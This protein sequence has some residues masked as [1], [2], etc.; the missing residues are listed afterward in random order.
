MFR[1]CL[2]GTAVTLA[3]IAIP[4]VH[5][6]TALPAPF[7]GGY[8]A[9][10]RSS[11]SPGQALIIG[12]AMGA[13]LLVPIGGILGLTAL[14]FHFSAQLMLALTMAYA[15]YVAALGTLGA[16]VGGSSVR[17]QTAA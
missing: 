16:A 4:V 7:I 5:W 15:L 13:I 14:F 17:R 12:P 1:A 6:F 2:V 11:A 3:L 8:F 10:A 9:G